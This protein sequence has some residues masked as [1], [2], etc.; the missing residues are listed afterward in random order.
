MNKYKQ[1]KTNKVYEIYPHVNYNIICNFFTLYKVPC[2]KLIRIFKF[3]EREHYNIN[4]Y[5]PLDISNIYVKILD[6]VER[7]KSNNMHH[8]IITVDLYQIFFG[9]EYGQKIFDKKR[10]DKSVK[11]K[12]WNKD[13]PEVAASGYD[14]RK[15]NGT[16]GHEY[17]C[18]RKEYWIKQGFSEDESIAK[19]SEVQSRG[20]VFF[21]NKYGIEQGTILFNERNEKWI[22]TINSKPQIELDEINKKRGTFSYDECILRGMSHHDAVLFIKKVYQ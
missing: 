18:R 5:T 16:I 6:R 9:D 2:D 4:N 19:I 7:L 10:K 14:V 22:S 13:N 21:T 8:S 15:Q 12:Q 11:C 1:F 3:I 20:L 17:S